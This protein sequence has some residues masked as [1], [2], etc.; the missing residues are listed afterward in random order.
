MIR[1]ANTGIGH[2]DIKPDK[3]IRTGIT[4]DITHAPEPAVRDRLVDL[5]VELLD[6]RQ[7]SER[8]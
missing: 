1:P 6:E 4:V 8:G 2:R 3:P 7:H 5:L